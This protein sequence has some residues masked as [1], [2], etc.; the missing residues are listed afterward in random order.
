M[1]GAGTE[2]P[3][4][5]VTRRRRLPGIGASV[6]LVWACCLLLA[7]PFA[8]SEWLIVAAAGLGYPL[9]VLYVVLEMFRGSADS[10]LDPVL[11]CACMASAAASGRT[12]SQPADP[13]SAGGQSAPG[14]RMPLEGK[15]PHRSPRGPDQADASRREGE[16]T[17][18]RRKQVAASPAQAAT[19]VQS[20]PGP[21]PSTPHSSNRLGRETAAGIESRKTNASRSRDSG[22]DASKRGSTRPEPSSQAQSEDSSRPRTT[23]SAT[24]AIMVLVGVSGLLMQISFFSARWWG[25]TISGSQALFASAACMFTAFRCALALVVMHNEVTAV[26]NQ[27][28]E[29]NKWR[30]QAADARLDTIQQFTR[31]I[32]HEARVPLQAVSLAVHELRAS[33]NGIRSE[34]RKLHR[35]L[36]SDTSLSSTILEEEDIS[37][38]SSGGTKR[39]TQLEELDLR[40]GVEVEDALDVL[41]SQEEGC[42]GLQL[43]FDD[44]L[45]AQRIEQ[46][47]LKLRDEVVDIGNVLHD[48]VSTFKP[49]AT[50]KGLELVADSEAGMPGQIRGDPVRIKQVVANLV[51][52][53]LKFTES[54]GRVAIHVG[55][56]ESPSHVHGSMADSRASGGPTCLE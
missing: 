2:I 53:A 4:A 12:S 30:R 6:L 38:S 52:N 11:S 27:V 17:S 43:I 24:I 49:T 33:L 36:Q 8:G 10:W 18:S 19:G 29:T 34:R 20:S 56:A 3:V 13:P 48:I 31:Y 23:S 25:C 7:F 50:A 55:M 45:E 28:A 22:Q 41:R 42:K 47:R 44:V 39:E 51:S 5:V 40:L 15:T 35:F 37:R 46:G 54:G 14:S 9:A 26:S 16:R 32:F 1:L 21:E